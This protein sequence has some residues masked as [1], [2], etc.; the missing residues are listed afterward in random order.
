MFMDSIRALLGDSLY[1]WT[2]QLGQMMDWLWNSLL[3]WRILVL[4]L[5]LCLIGKSY[6]RPK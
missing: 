6:R 2:L 5:V 1:E 4:V 3:I